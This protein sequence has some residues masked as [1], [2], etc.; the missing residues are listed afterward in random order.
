M[1]S[2]QAEDVVCFAN[3]Y[4]DPYHGHTL[5]LDRIQTK[6]CDSGI[7]F[8]CSG[9]CADFWPDYDDGPLMPDIPVYQTWEDYLAG[10]DSVLKYILELQ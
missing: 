8:K 5:V 2:R 9:L 6:I 3:T 7:K 10:Y 4:L 1:K